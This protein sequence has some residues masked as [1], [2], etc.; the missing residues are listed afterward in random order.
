MWNFLNC[1]FVVEHLLRLNIR[2]LRQTGKQAFSL[3]TLG[4]QRPLWHVDGAVKDSSRSRS[5][6]VCICVCMKGFF[7]FVFS[8]Q[9]K[10][11]QASFWDETFLSPL[12]C[13]IMRRGKTNG[14]LHTLYKPVSLGLG[15]TFQMFSAWAVETTSTMCSPQIALLMNSPWWS[16]THVYSKCHT[17]NVHLLLP[18]RLLVEE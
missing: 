17:N 7:C 14:A 10:R 3:G 12:S 15:T 1:G 2:P 5:I 11:H 9:H 16:A 6:C 8:C 13:G 4:T 18:L